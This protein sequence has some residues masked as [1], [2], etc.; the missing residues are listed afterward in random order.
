MFSKSI[1]HQDIFHAMAAIQGS[2]GRA[3]F[4]NIAFYAINGENGNFVEQAI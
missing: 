3:L 2:V 1:E 4:M